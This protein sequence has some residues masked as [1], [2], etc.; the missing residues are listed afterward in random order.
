MR[1]G[2]LILRL[3]IFILL[4][5][6]ILKTFL[7]FSKASVIK[8]NIRV[9]TRKIIGRIPSNWKALAQGGEEAGVDMLAN[10]V[11]QMSQLYPRYIRLDHIYDFYDV[12]ARDQNNQLTFNWQKLDI[13]VCDILR[14]G[15]KPFLSLGYMPPA[16]SSD[17]SLISAPQNWSDWALVVQKTIERYSGKN[18]VLCGQMNPNFTSDIYYEVWNEPDLETFG[19][20]SLYGGTKDYKTLYY[21]SSLGATSAT[22]VN[23]FNL[24]GPVTT[25]LYQSWVQNLLDYVIVN[26]L[27]LDFI[28]WH[29]YTKNPQDYADD[30]IKLNSWLEADKYTRFRLIPKIISEWGYDSEPNPIS[31]TNVGAAHTIMSI[32]NLIDQNL[33]MAFAF[34]IKDGTAP[35]WG[36]LT[37][38]GKKKPRYNALQFLNL[39]GENRLLIE[40]EGTFTKGIAT[41]SPEK[42]T[43][44]LV[45]FD[46]S[47]NN[48]E[49][50]PTTF[51]NLTPGTY[52][53]T[54]QYLYGEPTTFA[55]IVVAGDELRRNILMPPNMVIALE[56]RRQ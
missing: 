38:E 25:A 45:N 46:Q 43:L 29:H 18:T 9:N 44:I 34:E 19:K 26:N 6:I 1:F 5:F 40:G 17:G 4:S 55:D 31:E 30:V 24:G 8:P 3:A 52:S 20:W 22:E 50:V 36:I 37:H 53:L 27:R 35:R 51:T 12:V 49:M 39:L 15:A 54:L 56:L 33:D 48:T 2:R 42:I 32:R 47:N 14:S 23:N 16:L 21:Y 10:V 11:P 41:Y 13:T 28:S 7:Y